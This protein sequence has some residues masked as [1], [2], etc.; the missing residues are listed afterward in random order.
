ML[1]S[2]K[3]SGLTSQI[4]LELRVKDNA[5]FKIWDNSWA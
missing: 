4:I 5:L 1:S 2:P 3:F